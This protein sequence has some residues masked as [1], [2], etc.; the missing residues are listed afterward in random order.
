MKAFAMMMMLTPLVSGCVTATQGNLDALCAGTRA[1]R[2]EHAAA[3]VADGGPRSVV[4]GDR[5]IRQV[6]AACR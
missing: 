5:L 2:S 1:A 4:T 6:D 3:L